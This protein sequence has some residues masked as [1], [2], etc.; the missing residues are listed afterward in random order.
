MQ[1]HFTAS[2]TFLDIAVT[3]FRGPKRVDSASSQFLSPEITSVLPAINPRYPSR[4]TV[5]AVIGCS[6]LKSTVFSIPARP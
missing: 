6:F 2:N 4:A 3:S 1:F 5:L